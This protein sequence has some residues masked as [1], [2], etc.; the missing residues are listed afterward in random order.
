MD[1]KINSS[2][3]LRKIS[4]LMTTLPFLFCQTS[5]RK[6]NLPLILSFNKYILKYLPCIKHGN[7]KPSFFFL[8]PTASFRYNPSLPFLWKTETSLVTHNAPLCHCQSNLS[9]WQI[10]FLKEDS[11]SHMNRWLKNSSEFSQIKC[12]A[13]PPWN[14]RPSI[15]RA[16]LSFLVLSPNTALYVIF[17]QPGWFP[18]P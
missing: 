5:Y 16:Q 15:T 8:F 2:N 6:W 1:F 3:Y 18:V 14:L 13:S 10:R 7:G 4:S 17:H 12:T 11:S 9:S